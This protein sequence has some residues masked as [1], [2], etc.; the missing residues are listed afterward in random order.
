MGF[1]NDARGLI[2]AGTDFVYLDEGAYG[3]IFVSRSLGRVRK[4]YRHSADE[5]HAC[6]VFRSEI[7]AYARASASTE[8]MTLI[9]E[10]FQICSP[11]RVF[12][13]YGADVSNEF[14]PE[15]AFEMEFVDSRFQ[16]IGTI[17]QDEAQ[18]VHALFR[19]VGILH[20]LDMSVAL[21]ED[22]CVA[23]VIDFAM[24]EHEVWH[25]G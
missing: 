7:E 12:D 1:A 5:R 17:A 24:I 2:L 14:L 10:G 3:I 22:G 13:R 6:A 23:K 15:L 11:Q 18:R 16:K 25:Q 4:V 19:S 21:A 8:L 9:P 20:T